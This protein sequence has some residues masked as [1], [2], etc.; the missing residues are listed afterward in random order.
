M[1][2]SMT[3][4]PKFRASGWNSQLQVTRSRERLCRS[5]LVGFLSVFLFDSTRA[6]GTSQHAAGSYLGLAPSSLPSSLPYFNKYL[7]TPCPGMKP[8]SKL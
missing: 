1:L 4:N 7:L 6:N 8:C 2:S 5:Y 3:L